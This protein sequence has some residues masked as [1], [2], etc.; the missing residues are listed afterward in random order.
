MAAMETD[1]GFCGGLLLFQT[2]TNH[3][4][5]N[6]MANYYA[7]ARSNY[8]AVKDEMTFR[9]WAEFAGLKV[10]EPTYAHV[11]ADGIRRFAITPDNGDE[12]GW[13]DHRENAETGEFDE[14]DVPREL[15]A[16]LREGEVAVLMEVGS[17]KLR[18]L[19]G[20]ATALNSSGKSVHMS[21]EGIYARARK[22]GT[23]ITRAEY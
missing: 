6:K 17:E 21:L 23:N 11:T 20:Y 22:L 18:Y 12:A 2:P 7:T 5:H 1:P 19:C 13:P 10:L 3:Q 9:Q 15:A 16:H 14:V 4:P 8:F